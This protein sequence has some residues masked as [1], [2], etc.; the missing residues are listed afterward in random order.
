M[1]VLA[2]A[3]LA[4]ALKR[5]WK[6]TL[7][8]IVGL[9]FIVNQDMWDETVETLVLVVGR[10]HHVDGARRADRAS[11]QRTIRASTACCSRSST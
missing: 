7:G 8:V 6:L 1:L 5:S 4:Y 11:G 9:L 10:G 2:I 3:A